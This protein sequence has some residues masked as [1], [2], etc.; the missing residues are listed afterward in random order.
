MNLF[1][2]KLCILGLYAISDD[3]TAVVKEDFFGKLNEVIVEIKNSREILIAGDFNSRRGEKMNDLLVGP[4]GEEVI[5][6]N[7]DKLIDIYEKNSLKILKGYFKHII[8]HHYTW[9]QDT[10]ELRSVIDYIIARQNSGLK[11]QD[12]RVFR[13]MTVGSDHYLVNA[14]MLFLYGK[15]NANESRENIPVCAVELLQSAIYNIDSS[16]FI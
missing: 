9:H 16:F 6:D 14:K 11:F 5:N 4:I 10:Q 7:G 13:G 2:K 8:V 3:E 1:G 15:S 12:V